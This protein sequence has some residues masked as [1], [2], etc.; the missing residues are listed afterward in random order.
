MFRMKKSAIMAL[1]VSTA[2]TV[3]PLGVAAE[4]T[5]DGNV[6]KMAVTSDN[7]NF[8]RGI[9]DQFEEANPGKKVEIV[10]L[11]QGSDMYTKI[12]M[13]MQS[14]ETAP[15]LFT[16]DGFMVISDAQAGYLED[17]DDFVSGWE[18]ADQYEETLMEGGKGEDGKQYAIPLS[19][20]IQCLWYNKNLMEKAGIEVPF[21][22]KTWDDILE[23]GKK[24]KEIGGDDFIPFFLFASKTQPEE[25]SMRTFQTLYS[26]T[27]G[28]LYDFDQQKW[29]VDKENLLKVFNFVNDVYNVEKL[30][31]PLSIVSQNSLEDLFT[32]DHMKN[33]KLGMI[34]S[35]SWIP[36]SWKE[37]KA[38]EWAECMDTWAVAKI[39]TCDGGGA[40]YTTMS[41][42]WTW[43]IPKNSQNKEGG[44]ELLKFVA[45][46]DAQMQYAL[47]SGNLT[48]RKDVAKEPAYLEQEPSVAGEAGEMLQYTHFRPS[49]EGYSTLTTMFTEVIESIA[50]GVATP[51]EAVATF[52]SEM[53]RIVGGDRVV[54]K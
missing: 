30:G 6:I 5:G 1:A 22:P 21:E 9:A 33:D 54:V 43:A 18:D 8:W 52:E 19:T 28:T 16:E 40:G 49:V 14:P 37:G 51:E 29:I 50:M 15:D 25:T 34:I 44:M 48:V 4:G 2:L 3:C 39:P 27:G 24:L 53:L 47:H 11:E 41:G 36:G 38:S 32:S 46:K 42:G 13:M 12:M 10:E 23:A 7:V 20:D 26:G 31:A 35:G 17:L 45:G